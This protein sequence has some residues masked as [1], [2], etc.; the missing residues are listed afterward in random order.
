[1]SCNIPMNITPA[2][3]SRTILESN[4]PK[5]K[6]NVPSYNTNT[7]RSC[8]NIQTKTQ[9]QQPVKQ[10]QTP[11]RQ[12]QAPV[13]QQAKPI[14]TVQ[15]PV[16]QPVKSVPVPK[17]VG[18]PEIKSR[19]RKGQKIDIANNGSIHKV[20]ILIGWD[21]KDSR[22]DVDMSAFMLDTSGKCLGD[23]W[24]VFYGQPISKDNSIRYNKFENAEN[25]VTKATIDINFDKIN[26]TI[27]KIAIVLTIDEALKNRL[28]FSMLT[29]TY[30]KIVDTQ[31]HNEI[32]RF[33]LDEYYK[34]VTSMVLGE[35]YKHNNTWKLNCV[36]NGVSKDL[37][38]LCDMYGI[39]TT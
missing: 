3:T 34:E 37:A 5:F 30:I 38:G 36:G 25:S 1:M 29:N 8:N 16:Q 7:I 35:I 22:C 15:R 11:H 14:Q 12:S 18:L 13:Q 4:T 24:F 20:K 6:Q 10:V 2:F 23:E 32:C 33:V 39:E 17:Q 31:T 27:S 26:N 19:V 28:N 9:T 21:I